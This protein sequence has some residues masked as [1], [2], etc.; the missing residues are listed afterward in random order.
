MKRAFTRLTLPRP[1]E[2]YWGRARR[3]HTQVW[4]ISVACF[5]AGAVVTKGPCTKVTSAGEAEDVLLSQSRESKC[6]HMLTRS[7]T[8]S[9][10]P[11]NTG[12]VCRFTAYQHGILSKAFDVARSARALLRTRARRQW[13]NDGAR[14]S[15]A[16]DFVVKPTEDVRLPAARAVTLYGYALFARR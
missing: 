16:I 9:G 8:E 15:A 3:P 4:R 7:L 14:S 12:R 1:T 11:T 2:P 5:R 10:A 13:W 6:R